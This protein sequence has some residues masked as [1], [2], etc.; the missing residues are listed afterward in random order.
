MKGDCP[1]TVQS[2]AAIGRGRQPVNRN[3]CKIPGEHDAKGATLLGRR[4]AR[5]TGRKLASILT[6]AKTAGLWPQ[7][8]YDQE[9]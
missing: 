2:E 1:K 6:H 4:A 7:K 8:E 9:L 3:I 5:N